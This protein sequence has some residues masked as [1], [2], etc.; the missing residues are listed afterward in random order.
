MA[1]R[2]SLF[3]SDLRDTPDGELLVAGRVVQVSSEGFRISDA[4]ATVDIHGHTDVDVGDLLVVSVRRASGRT[5]L[6]GLVERHRR[7]VFP[8]AETT[9]FV[10]E[11]VGPILGARAQVFST[12]RSYFARERFVEVDTPL[13]V[14]SPGLD[15][16]LDAV[17][18]DGGYLIT[19]P[20]YQMKRLLA[21]G[22]PRIFQL[23]HVFRHGE[24][25][26]RH[27]PEFM[28]L[29][30][31]RAFATIDDLMRDTETLVAE[32]VF[33][34]TQSHVLQGDHGPVAIVPPFGRM[35]VARAFERFARVAE[36]DLFA[37]AE[38]DS[39]TY[40]RLLVEKV[41]PALAKE[42][43]PIFLF[44]FPLSQ[45]SLA[46]AKPGDPRV[47]ERF[48]LYVGGVELCNGFGELTDAAEQRRRF[49]RDQGARRAAGKP[50]YPIDERFLAA[51]EEG[52]PP[53][54]GNALGVDRLIALSAGER[55]IARV[56]PFP[57][58]H[59]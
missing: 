56:M 55:E 21:G 31:Y 38:H 26:A 57:A 43:G 13:L 42:P 7:T 33:G 5:E 12:I 9:R 35:A 4:F 51:L 16:H 24:V 2:P 32:I 8:G 20:E 59:L 28:M 48:E 27:N 25:G 15:L 11:G 18:A 22:F 10:D 23:S 40:F 19:S 1:T 50:V 30:W 34:Q 45:A 47:C 36:D 39:E 41:E 54:A 44:D 37:M 17:E 46:R 53:S 14:R 3:P 49:E 29:E 6:V 52:L 58:G